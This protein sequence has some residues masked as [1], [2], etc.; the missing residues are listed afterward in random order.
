MT[1]WALQDL[2]EFNQEKI[3]IVLEGKLQNV[4]RIKKL[5]FAERW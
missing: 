2:L 4:P 1:Q 3:G 5:E